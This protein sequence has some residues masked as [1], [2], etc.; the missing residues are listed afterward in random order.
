V[1]EADAVRQF[2]RRGLPGVGGQAGH[3]VL[4]P[5]QPVRRGGRGG[6]RAGAGAGPGHLALGA[7]KQADDLDHGARGGVAV[8]GSQHE[9]DDR[10]AESGGVQDPSRGFGERGDVSRAQRLRV[11]LIA[12]P[13]VP[14]EQPVRHPEGPQLPGRRRGG[15]QREQVAEQAPAIGQVVIGA[16]FHLG[17]PPVGH[18]RRDGE[19]RHH[20]QW[21]PDQGE[22]HGC[23]HELDAGA[24]HSQR[25][26]GRAGQGPAAFSQPVDLGQV[27]GPLEVLKEGRVA[28]EAA[29]PQAKT[30]VGQIGHLRVEGASD[31]LQ[32]PAAG[33]CDG[34]DDQA[35]H[36]AAWMVRERPVHDGPEAERV[37][38]HEQR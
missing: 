18:G 16:L 22:Q 10:D 23:P 7:A 25:L 14:G 13:D 24:D 8:R 5:D 29:D 11:D 37:G 34:H 38:Q 4:E 1:I 31:Q 35:R 26:G 2:G 28:G 27:V 15:S 21:R 17:R 20:D 30:Q 32:H 12:E 9:G 33:E 36:D 6:E 19:Q 3:V